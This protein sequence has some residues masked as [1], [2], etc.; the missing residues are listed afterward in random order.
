MELAHLL[1]AAGADEAGA[2]ADLREGKAAGAVPAEALLA[3]A[4]EA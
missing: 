3:L 1:V 2:A 4:R